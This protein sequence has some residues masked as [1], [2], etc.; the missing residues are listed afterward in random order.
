MSGIL[1]LEKTRWIETIMTVLRDSHTDRATFRKYAELMGDA[2]VVEAI[3]SG[4]IPTYGRAVISP[5][6][7]A[8][9]GFSLGHHP[10]VVAV[11]IVRAGNAFVNSV[12]RL[13]GANTELGQLVIQRDENT[14]LPITLLEKVPL[15][16]SAAECVLLLDPMLATGGSVLAAISVLVAH[17]VRPERIVL[18]HALGC[19]EGIAAITAAYPNI[20]AVIGVVDSH[21]NDRKFIIPGLGDFGDRFFC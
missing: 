1:V 6:G 12:L 2:L 18:L 7:A 13:V 4:Y 19:P 11:S 16:I 21:L 8:V 9:Q 10:S 17:G 14:A 5:T 15:T 3:N 20:R